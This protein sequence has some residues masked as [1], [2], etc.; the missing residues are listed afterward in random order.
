MTLFCIRQGTTHIHTHTHTHTY[1]EMSLLI[2]TLS[3]RYYLNI[4]G[5]HFNNMTGVERGELRYYQ[6]RA[7]MPYHRDHRQGY[8]I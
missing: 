3:D 5:N 2:A 6:K 7:I 4:E 1:L 8:N